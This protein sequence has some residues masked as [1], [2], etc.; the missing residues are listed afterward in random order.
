MVEYSRVRGTLGL[1]V[2]GRVIPKTRNMVHAVPPCLAFSS[3]GTNVE[4]KHRVL[5]DGQPPTVAFTVHAYMCGPKAIETDISPYS[6][7]NG[8]GESFD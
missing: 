8:E 2:A 1:L 7:K 5:L 4:V 6:T 3:L